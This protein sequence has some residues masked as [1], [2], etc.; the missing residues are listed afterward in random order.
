MSIGQ[1][2]A[3]AFSMLIGVVGMVIAWVLLLSG[4]KSPV[5]VVI[6]LGSVVISLVGYFLWKKQKKENSVKPIEESH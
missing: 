3:A 2:I 5:L 4:V 6:E 1:K